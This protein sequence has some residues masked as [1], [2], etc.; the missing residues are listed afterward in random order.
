[1]T[2]EYLFVG[3]PKHGQLIEVSDGGNRIAFDSG[4]DYQPYFLPN[5]TVIVYV[6]KGTD[7]SVGLV[8]G[9]INEF[10]QTEQEASETRLKKAMGM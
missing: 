4:G 7:F 3:G 8:G 6:Q 5:T 9:A 10:F 2:K 1:M